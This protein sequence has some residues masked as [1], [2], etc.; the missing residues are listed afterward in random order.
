MFQLDNEPCLW[1]STHRDVHPIPLTYD[2]LWNFTESYASAVKK[3]YPN[4]KIFGPVFWGWC[5]YMFSPADGC[6]D[7]PDRESHGDLP[8]LQWYISQL[9]QYQQQTGVQ[10]VD[11]IDIH[12]YPQESNVDSEDEDPVTAALRLSST[13]GLWDPTYVDQSWINQPVYILT[14]IIEWLQLYKYD[15]GFSLSEFNWGGDDL[16][17]TALATADVVGILS[18]FGAT[19]GTKWVVPNSGSRTENAYALFLNFDGK[20][21]AVG[22][23]Y[24][25][26]TT[27]NIEE[28][29]AYAYDNTTSSTVT[30]L[31]INK[32]ASGTTPVTVDLSSVTQ[33]ATAQLYQLTQN[34]AL[35]PAGTAKVSNGLLQLNLPFWSATIVAVPY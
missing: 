21:T 5:A 27:S 23:V 11:V 1:D 12:F 18:R 4:S 3:A 9:A 25:N 29:G 19:L 6:A 32:Y 24:L 17:T 22:N 20:N 31:L 34:Q 28:V 2:E 14:R 33:S 35:S 26:T 16:I 8:F 10:L 15:A 13:R 7:G 30:V